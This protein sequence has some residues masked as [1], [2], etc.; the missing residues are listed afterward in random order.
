MFLSKRGRERF[1][2]APRYGRALFNGGA[3]LVF[4]SLTRFQIAFAFG[5]DLIF[6]DH[7]D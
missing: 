4:V 6:A 5:S 3:S 1:S 2:P 7:R